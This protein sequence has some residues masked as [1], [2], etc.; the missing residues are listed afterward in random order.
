MQNRFSNQLKSLVPQTALRI[1]KTTALGVSVNGDLQSRL[2]DENISTEATLPEGFRFI[3]S[4]PSERENG[5][6]FKR[7]VMAR[8]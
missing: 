6:L 5:I 8:I 7:L 2:D 3:K 4:G 1:S